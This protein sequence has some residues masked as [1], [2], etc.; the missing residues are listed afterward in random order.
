MPPSCAASMAGTGCTH[1]FGPDV[2]QKNAEAGHGLVDI[3][4]QDPETL[5][6][7]RKDRRKNRRKNA[8]LKERGEGADRRSRGVHERRG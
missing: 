8:R 3:D 1:S 5:V 6:F 7:T 2:E 4:P